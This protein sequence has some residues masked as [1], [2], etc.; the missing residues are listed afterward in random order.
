MEETEMKKILSVL[1]I[2]SCLF[3]FGALAETTPATD[4][5]T[6]ESAIEVETVANGTV[7][8]FADHN[9]QVTLPSD[10]N[11]LEISEEEAAAG[12]IYSCANPEGT[13]TFTIAYTELDAATD[14]DAIA[15]ELAA[16]YENVEK[17]TINDIPFVSYDITESD[18]TGL[19]TL[20]ASGVGLYQFVFYPASDSDYGT[21]ALQIAASITTIE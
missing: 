4:A 17:F 13:R 8:P 3:A 6:E 20:G 2:L 10:W 12:I 5:V 9:F 18:V 1:L 14:I 19:M 16:S 7:V 15:A 21:L 11:V